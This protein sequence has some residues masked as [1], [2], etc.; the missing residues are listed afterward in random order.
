[1]LLSPLAIH[2]SS[3]MLERFYRVA[4]VSVLLSWAGLTFFGLCTIPELRFDD[5]IHLQRDP[6]LALAWQPALKQIWTENHVAYWP[7]TSTAWYGLKQVATAWGSY[8]PLYVANVLLHLC[9]SLAA[10]LILVQLFASPVAA[11]WG[12]L[13]FAIHPLHVEPVAWLTGLRDV[14]SGALALAS[15]FFYVKWAK[16]GYLA[17]LL[18]AWGIFVLSVLSKPNIAFFWLA[19]PFVVLPWKK[20]REQKLAAGLWLMILPVLVYQLP[21]NQATTDWLL[22]KTTASAKLLVALDA[23]TFYVAKAF[24]P[25]QTG[26]DYGRT[27]AR[28]LASAEIFF[29]VALPPLLFLV[30]R[31]LRLLRFGAIFILALLPSLGLVPFIHQHISTVT[32]RYAYVA[33]FAF[34]AGVSAFVVSKPRYQWAVLGVAIVFTFL[35]LSQ[36]GI[37]MNREALFQHIVEVNPRSWLGHN[38]I[39]ALHAGRSEVDKAVAEFKLGIASQDELRKK[40]EM[41]NFLGSYLIGQGRYFEA[42]RVIQQAVEIRPTFAK[43]H[44][45]LG[46]AWMKLGAAEHAEDEF[47]IALTW[48]PKLK[49]SREGLREA[50]RL[51]NP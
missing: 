15:L 43:G 31:R 11:F 17:R 45:N 3:L 32:D 39:A 49:E 16:Q 50:S 21:S 13:L 18:V 20:L 14:L 7:L 40:P 41:L 30:L 36:V 38:S 10:Y 44:H 4:L 19:F 34:A 6:R 22:D 2:Y 42:I 28:A 8:Q 27:P 26:F 24:F 47:W 33:L 46:M 1:M 5:P 9:A 12:A 48:D 23:I 25:F 37:W 35:S 29:T 51:Q